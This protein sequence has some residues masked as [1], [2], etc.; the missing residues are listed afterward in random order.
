MSK[1]T[2]SILLGGALLGIIGV[3][4]LLWSKEYL[5]LLGVFFMMWGNNMMLDAKLAGI[6]ESNTPKLIAIANTLDQRIKNA[7]KTN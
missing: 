2:L 7:R 4:I 5:V 1:S 6:I 3:G